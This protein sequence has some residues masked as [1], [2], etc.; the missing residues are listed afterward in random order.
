MLNFKKEVELYLEATG[1]KPTNLFRQAG[2]SAM[3]AT[4]HKQGKSLSVDSQRAVL[5][6]LRA[7][8]WFESTARK[9][10]INKI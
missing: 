4:F 7:V 3:T 1:V 9:R 5:N 10:L 8:G 2:L 6:H